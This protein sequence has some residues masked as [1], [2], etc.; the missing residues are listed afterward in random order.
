[1]SAKGREKILQA[2]LKAMGSAEE[3]FQGEYGRSWCAA[4]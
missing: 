2:Q 3:N 1:M 4:A